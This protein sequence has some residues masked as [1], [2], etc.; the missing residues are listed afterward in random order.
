M[1][2][3]VV[4]Y[5]Y[6]FGRRR[7]AVAAQQHN[8]N[9]VWAKPAVGCRRTDWLVAAI[10]YAAAA[11]PNDPNLYFA[12]NC[13]IVKTIGRRILFKMVNCLLFCRC[14]KIYNLSEINMSNNGAMRRPLA[15]S[16]NYKP[17]NW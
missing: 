10:Y 3:V 9:I 16:P 13:L 2:N 6:L 5:C 12:V 11:L 7:A 1:H 4:C 15:F 14:A 17:N 8:R